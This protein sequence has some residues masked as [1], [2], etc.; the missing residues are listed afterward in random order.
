MATECDRE[1]TDLL[2]TPAALP[3]TLDTVISEVVTVTTDSDLKGATEVPATFISESNKCVSA[4][5]VSSVELHKKVYVY[6]SFAVILVAV[7][8]SISPYIFGG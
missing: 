6:I 4:I 1:V 3:M 5:V 2:L 8:V 7:C